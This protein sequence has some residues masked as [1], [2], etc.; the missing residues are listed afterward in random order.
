MRITSPKLAPVLE[1]IAIVTLTGRLKA[2][3]TSKGRS[4]WWAGLLPLLWIIGELCGGIG[5]A[6]AGLDGFALYIGA[7]AG[8]AA[9]AGIAWAIVGSLAPDELWDNDGAFHSD[10][11]AGGHHDPNNPYNA[12]RA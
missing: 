7:I 10:G 9:G 12:P 8:A 6:M 3:A 11:V 1:I 4:G 2:V 5:A